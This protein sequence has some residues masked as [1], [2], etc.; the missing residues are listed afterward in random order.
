MSD[1]EVSGAKDGFLRFNILNSGIADTPNLVPG[2]AGIPTVRNFEFRNIKVTD[3]PELVHGVEIHPHKPLDGFVLQNVT[4][5]C[6]KG[7]ELANIRNAHLS[8]IKVTA[9]DG[10]LLLTSNVSG[11]GLAGATPIQEVNLPKVPDSILP[12]AEPYKLH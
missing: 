5:T 3:M 6:K 4:G 2:D 8:G 12:P 9:F 1:L 7:I 10:P 11:T